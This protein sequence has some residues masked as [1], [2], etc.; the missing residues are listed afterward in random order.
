MELVNY[1]IE[2]DILTFYMKVENFP[3]GIDATFTKFGELLNGFEGH[4][5]YGVSG[6]FDGELIYR[7]S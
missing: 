3:E 1:E 4:E 5:V 6:C 2:N 7:C